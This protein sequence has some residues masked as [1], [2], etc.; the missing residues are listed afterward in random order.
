VEC[1]EAGGAVLGLH[2]VAGAEAVQQRFDDPPHVRI[3]IDDQQ[4][5]AIEID[6]NHTTSAV[7]TLLTLDRVEIGR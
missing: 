6:A 4:T 2:H 7:R 5:Q 3:V 1:V